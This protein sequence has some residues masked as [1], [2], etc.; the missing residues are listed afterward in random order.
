[1][2]LGNKEFHL[3]RFKGSFSRFIFV[4]IFLD[5]TLAIIEISMA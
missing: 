4:V 5:I 1:V 2:P 3:L